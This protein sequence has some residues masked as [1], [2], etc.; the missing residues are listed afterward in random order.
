MG[1]ITT[2]ACGLYQALDL[3]G[4]V[5]LYNTGAET[6]L[7]TYEVPAGLINQRGGYK[8]AWSGFITSAAAASAKFLRLKIN[9]ALVWERSGLGTTTDNNQFSDELFLLLNNSYTEAYIVNFRD[10]TASAPIAEDF[11][12]PWTLTVTGD[13]PP[14]GD[15]GMMLGGVTLDVLE[16]E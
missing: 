7:Y 12:L 14:S 9:G 16:A 10:S 11:S 2:P 3:G 8:I 4:R 15:A 6:T 13:L 1:Q 5:G